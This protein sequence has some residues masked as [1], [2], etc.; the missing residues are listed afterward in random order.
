MSIPKQYK[1]DMETIYPDTE[2]WEG[3][4]AKVDAMSERFTEH[5][6]KLGESSI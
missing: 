3:D 6:G 1:W 5:A 4:F 2:A